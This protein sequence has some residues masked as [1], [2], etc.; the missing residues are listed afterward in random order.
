M[1][2]KKH[3]GPNLSRT[4]DDTDDDDDGD[5][6]GDDDDADDDDD[7]ADDDGDD[8]ANLVVAHPLPDQRLHPPPSS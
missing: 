3:P 2:A 5:D 1:P 7:D 6:D 4:N 8:D